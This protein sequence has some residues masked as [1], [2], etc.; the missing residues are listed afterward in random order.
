MPQRQ[1]T[2]Q[3]P[4]PPRRKRSCCGLPLILAIVVLLLLI[5]SYIIFLRPSIGAFLGEQI[6]RQLGITRDMPPIGSTPSAADE[7]YPASQADQAMEQAAQ[8]LPTAIAALPQGEI[9]VS[10]DELNSY[11]QANMHQLEAIDDVVVQFEPDTVM[12]DLKAFRTTSTATFGLAVRDGRI[13]TVNPKM[14]GPLAFVVPF[15][16]LSQSLEEQIN[17]ELNAQGRAITD[18]RI[19]QDQ[20]VVTVE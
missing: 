5:E 13:V 20:I 6:G 8:T 4:Q 3:H 14:S 2:P 10:E 9:V 16:E 12:L 17:N 7:P 1:V 11:V 19:E 15:D 18:V